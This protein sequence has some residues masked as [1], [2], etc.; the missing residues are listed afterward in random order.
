MLH[1]IFPM[2]KEVLRPPKPNSSVRVFYQDIVIWIFFPTW[3]TRGRQKYWRVSEYSCARLVNPYHPIQK[4]AC[5][6][7]KKQSDI[8]R[9]S[10]WYLVINYHLYIQ[11]R[12]SWYCHI[13]VPIPWPPLEGSVYSLTRHWIPITWRTSS[14]DPKIYSSRQVSIAIFWSARRRFLQWGQGNDSHLCWTECRARSIGSELSSNPRT[15]ADGWFT[16]IQLHVL[17]LNPASIELVLN[18]CRLVLTEFHEES[19]LSCGESWLYYNHACR[20]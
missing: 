15:C 6:S 4:P 16:Q 13:L 9:Q 3:Q 18:V 10:V 7:V 19:F 14:S 11:D 5:M 8:T 1:A 12:S 20:H 2:V 17:F